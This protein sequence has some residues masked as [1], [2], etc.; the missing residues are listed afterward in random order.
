MKNAYRTTAVR[1]VLFI[2]L[3][4]ASVVTAEQQTKPLERIIIKPGEERAQF[5]FKESKK[6]FFVK[7]F[8]Y[9]RLRGDHAT[10]DW[11]LFYRKMGSFE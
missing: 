7:G 10:D 6:P 5:I 3:T 8:N 9:V 1:M 4:I 11:E 2:L